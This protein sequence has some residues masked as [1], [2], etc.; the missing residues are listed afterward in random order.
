MALRALWDN[1]PKWFDQ[2]FALWRQ[3]IRIFLKAQQKRGRLQ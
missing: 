3:M 2:L 1:D